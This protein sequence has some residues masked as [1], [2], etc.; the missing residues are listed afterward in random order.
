MRGKYEN[1]IRW[2][3]IIAVL[4]GA[5]ILFSQMHSRMDLTNE[6]RFT[7]SKPVKVLLKKMEQ[8]VMI[9][10]FLKGEMPSGFRML[11]QNATE[12]LQEFKDYSGGKVQYEFVS[13]EEKIPG[14]DIPW[15]DTL[16]GMGILPINLKVQLKSGEQSQYIYP[17]AMVVGNN[18]MYGVNLYPSARPAITP[19]D[20]NDAEALFEYNFAS[21]IRKVL[22]E[23]KPMIA[24][25][26]GN[27]EPTDIRTFDLVQNTITPDYNLFT[28]D[29]TQQD[30]IPDTFQA[31]II[32]KPT[33]PFSD[34]E[35]LKIDQ[36]VMRG[37]RL[38]AFI[39]RLEA[40]MD[41]LQ[42]VNR[43]VAYDRGLNLEDLFFRYGVRINPDLIMDLQSDFLPFDVNNN[44]QF[45]LLHWNYFPLLQP[46]ETSVVTKNVGLVAGRFVNSI[47]T[48]KA[49]NVKKT[50][51]LA[52]SANSR[53][54]GTPA[55]ISSSENRN[56]PEDDAFQQSDIPAAVLLEGAFT[57]L[58]KNRLGVEEQQRLQAAGTPFRDEST[59]DNRMIV[60]ADGD[61]PLNNTYKG[62][63]LL[64]GVNAYTI[65]TQYEY[66]FANRNFVRNSLAYLVNDANLMEARSKDFKLRLLDAKKVNEQKSL[67]QLLNFAVPVILIILVGLLYRYIRQKRYRYELHKSHV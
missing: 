43:V 56:A 13:T 36:Y 7:I 63:P 60:V 21:G 47:D 29:L 53:T 2:V 42:I 12:L 10:L 30:D 32:V 20:L 19:E 39:D 25:A 50:I 64:M 49:D 38:L 5:N 31:L 35:K 40:E 66:R 57:S 67:W 4:I 15:A 59:P 17:A 1:I 22:E 41:S 16:Q 14:T 46:N 45:E 55:L 34:E 62:E 28:L 52:T 44:G 54:I 27:G 9:K 65:G 18:K 37:G 6:K 48:V 3:A 24:Y 8:P 58:F 51:L 23:S 11:S 33:R 26:T 61:I